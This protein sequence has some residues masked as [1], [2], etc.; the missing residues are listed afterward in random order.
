MTMFRYSRVCV[1]GHLTVGATITEIP[2]KAFEAN[3]HLF[4]SLSFAPDSRLK[5]IGDCTFGKYVNYKDAC[6]TGGTLTLPKT[7]E[8]IGSSAFAET[9]ITGE[10]V[11]PAALKEMGTAAFARCTG[12]KGGLQL[13]EGLKKRAKLC[14]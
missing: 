1:N 5:R 13:P 14:L 6:L 7:V 10:L 2:D 9:G 8:Y 4:S 3:G 11:L 12:L